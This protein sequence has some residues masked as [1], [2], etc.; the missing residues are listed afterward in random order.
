MGVVTMFAKRLKQI[1]GRHGAESS[2]LSL[3]FCSCFGRC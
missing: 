2:Q 3:L 1:C